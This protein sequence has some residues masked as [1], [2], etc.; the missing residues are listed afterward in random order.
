MQSSRQ[1]RYS[2]VLI[3]FVIAGL[4]LSACGSLGGPKTYKIGIV[5]YVAT[6][7]DVIQGFKTAMAEYGY[8]DGQNITYIYNGVMPN[9]PEVIGVEVQS[10]LD[11]KVDMLF[12]V[13]TVTTVVAKEATLGTDL[14]IVFAPVLNPV[15]EG[16]VDSI[17]HP[18]GNVTGVQTVNNGPKA[19]EW[20]VKLA[21]ETKQVYVFHANDGVTLNV[22]KSLPDVA[23]QLNVEVM[24]T[25]AASGEEVMSIM[26]TLPENSG[27]LMVPFPTLAAATDD[28]KHLAIEL[29]IPTGGYNDPGN[30]VVFGYTTDRAAQGAQAARLANLIFKGS[31]PG[32]LPVETAESFLRINVKTADSIGLG[33]PDE[34][35]RQADTVLR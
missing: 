21:P 19:L 4:L 8:V 3:V 15:G 26:R 13:G 20:L 29:G 28:I 5:N 1:F 27:I 16:V 10:L 23:A 22:I 7:G 9:D 30:D 14:P 11:Q 25:E 17:A 6:L 2:P 34:I 24:S 31:N 12:T 35:L 18:G 32:E 33:I